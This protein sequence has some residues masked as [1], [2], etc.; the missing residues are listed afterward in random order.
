MELS[1]YATSVPT[2]E[3]D[4]FHEKLRMSLLR[5]VKEGIDMRR[6][7]MIINREERQVKWP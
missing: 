5:I 6:M 3:L 7:T 1:I 2:G 4:S